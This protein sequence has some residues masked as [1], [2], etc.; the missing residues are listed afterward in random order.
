MSTRKYPGFCAD[1]TTRSKAHIEALDE[2]WSVFG[3]NRVVYGSNWPVSDLIAPYSK[4]Q[5]TAI[6]YFKTKPLDKYL[7]GNSQSIYR[8]GK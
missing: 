6:A 8:W 2:V 3:E 4:I 1:Q 5:E 7:S